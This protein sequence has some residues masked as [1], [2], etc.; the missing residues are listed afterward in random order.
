AVKLF[1]IISLVLSGRLFRAFSVLHFRFNESVTLMQVCRESTRRQQQLITRTALQQFSSLPSLTEQCASDRGTLSVHQSPIS[2]NST[3]AVLGRESGL[4][5]PKNPITQHHTDTA[6]AYYAAV[7]ALTKPSPQASSSI[8]RKL[9]APNCF[10]QHYKMPAPSQS[11]NV[12]CHPQRDC[13]LSGGHPGAAILLAHQKASGY[14]NSREENGAVIANSVSIPHSLSL[15]DLVAAGGSALSLLNAVT[16]PTS[17]TFVAATTSCHSRPPYHASPYDSP[18]HLQRQQNSQHSLQSRLNKID[19][20]NQFSVEQAEQAALMLSSYLEQDNP[21]QLKQYEPYISVPVT[22][23]SNSTGIETMDLRNTLNAFVHQQQQQQHLYRSSATLAAVQRQNLMSRC[24]K[25][26]T[27]AP[28]ISEQSA[29]ALNSNRSSEATLPST[30]KGSAQPSFSNSQDHVFAQPNQHRQVLSLHQLSVNR[31]PA[32]QACPGYPPSCTAIPELSDGLMKP[33]AS[34]A[35]PSANNQV[36]GTVSSGY[37]VFLRQRQAQR[38]N[39]IRLCSTRTPSPKTFVQIHGGTDALPI[40]LIT[41]CVPETNS[42][43]LPETFSNGVTAVGHSSHSRWIPSQMAVIDTT[44]LN[45]LGQSGNTKWTGAAADLQQT[46]EQQTL[47]VS[48]TCSL[49]SSQRFSMDQNSAPTSTTVPESFAVN[50]LEKTDLDRNTECKPHVDASLSSAVSCISSLRS[51]KKIPVGRVQPMIK[52]EDISSA[53][54]FPSPAPSVFN[55]VSVHQQQ[56]HLHSLQKH[57]RIPQQCIPHNSYQHVPCGSS[58]PNSTS[59]SDR[60]VFRNQPPHFSIPHADTQ[61][62]STRHLSAAHA[63]AAAYHNLM[64]FQL[65]QRQQQQQQQSQHQQLA[66]INIPAVST[67]HPLHLHSAQYCPAQ[68]TNVQ[69]SLA[70]DSWSS[71]VNPA[72]ELE[73]PTAAA[74]AS[75]YAAAAAAELEL[76]FNQHSLQLRPNAISAVEQQQQFNTD[77]FHQQHR[78]PL[79]KL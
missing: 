51:D 76:L 3:A 55:E 73:D 66:T 63:A 24:C 58:G 13:Q 25:P 59:S 26:V 27:V 69:L 60:A 30:L 33:I 29:L 34:T 70:S 72:S 43:S 49:S 42:Q 45:V 10:R 62:Q 56:Q 39:L 79:T 75:Y 65:Q 67:V 68:S 28:H 40:N 31:V 16:C 20:N 41:N 22:S 12:L 48:V 64:Y 47:P 6:V 74:A 35:T 8:D 50:R 46:S 36:F 54:F 2:S 5:L 53:R 21:R 61:T 38:A 4:C 78:H 17:S 11:T 7:A 44:S 18:Q 77:L 23:D 52:Q 1:S 71:V 9:A 15:Y 37:P 14:S 32:N 19:S 57:Q